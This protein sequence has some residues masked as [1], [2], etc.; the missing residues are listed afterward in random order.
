M[1]GLPNSADEAEAPREK[2]HAGR[3]FLFLAI[4]VGALGWLAYRLYPA[5]HRTPTNP[6]FIDSI[7]AN[8]LV[9]FVGR[10]VLVA[11]A[12]VLAVTAVLL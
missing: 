6:N 11:A 2:T 4:I 8:N 5:H 3:G 10:L 7:F 1:S 12:V 9:L